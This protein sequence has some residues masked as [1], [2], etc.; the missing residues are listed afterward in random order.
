MVRK[1]NVR[2]K[3]PLRIAV[4]VGTRAPLVSLPYRRQIRHELMPRTRVWLNTLVL[5]AF[6]KTIFDNFLLKIF[7]KH[8]A[9]SQYISRIFL[10]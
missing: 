5:F 9:G 7:I 3:N 6:F 10:V 8:L 2:K 1:N 4:P